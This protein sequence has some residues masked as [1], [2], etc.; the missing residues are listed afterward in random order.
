[1]N[2]YGT[3]VAADTVRIERLLPGPVERIWSWLTESDKRQLWLASGDMQLAPGG[4]VEFVFRNSE[5]TKNDVPPPP[6]YAGMAG[7]ATLQVT[8]LA[9]ELNRRLA[10]QWG[11]GPAA[12]E[13]T[14]DLVPK[15]D[16]VLLTVTH[17]R[18]P[19]REEM[20]SIS[21]GWHTHLDILADRLAGREPAGFWATHTRL[22]A[23]Y[24]R[25]VPNA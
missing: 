13:V 23:E 3:I 20:L 14:F 22:E 25:V 8:V 16:K 2:A 12:S 19:D 18:I 10:L 4:A 9:C 24:Q 17:R 5:L 6:K 21:S 11:A 15:G 1:M 7:P